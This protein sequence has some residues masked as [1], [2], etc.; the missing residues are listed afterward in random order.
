MRLIDGVVN[1]ARHGVPRLG[2]VL[3]YFRPASRAATSPMILFGAL[4]FIGYFVI[5]GGVIAR[6]CRSYL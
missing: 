2:E 4:V 5:E 1:G 3:R 6:S